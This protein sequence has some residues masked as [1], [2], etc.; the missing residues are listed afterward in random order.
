MRVKVP[1]VLMVVIV[2][3]E[4]SARAPQPGGARRWRGTYDPLSVE[5]ERIR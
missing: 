5:S 4:R 3:H 1:V 2:L